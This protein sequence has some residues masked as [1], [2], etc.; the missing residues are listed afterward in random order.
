[1][2]NPFRTIVEVK[3][4]PF[5]L[6]YSTPTLFVGSCFTENIGQMMLQRKFPAMVN[7]FGVVYNPVSV[8][9][10]LNRITEGKPY[11]ENELLEHNGQWLSLDHHTSFSRVDKQDC[12]NTI[13]SS[14]EEAT[15]FWNNTQCLVVT[16]GTARVY[17]YNRTELPVANCHKI[18]AKEFTNKLLS[19]KEIV[20]LWTN[21]LNRIFAS[22]PNLKIIITV[23][24]V[25]HWKDGP[26]GNQVSKATLLLAA[27]QLVELFPNRLFY[28]PAYEI[29]MDDLRDYRYYADDMLH[30][31]PLAISY[32]WDKYKRS[33]IHNTA[34][35]LSLEIEKV[36]QAVNHR[37]FNTKTKEFKQ[38]LERTLSKI[39]EI[40]KLN[41]SIN[42]NEEIN[43]LKGH[44]PN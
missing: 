41:P 7:P 17:Y 35:D 23:S 38:F 16:F 37:P 2:N 44:L 9:L 20:S 8:S 31:S 19:V 24:P 22:K 10:V 5:G 13:N 14:L 25:R 3:P 15:Q 11:T 30:P 18:P 4:L 43:T 21:D 42:F 40:T 26:F 32:I 1:M 39:N 29:M 34:Q 33:T 28:F 36:L 27:S 6:D 12:L